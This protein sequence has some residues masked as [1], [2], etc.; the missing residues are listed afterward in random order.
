MTTN[1]HN[2]HLPATPI[3]VEPT[4]RQMAA[5]ELLTAFNDVAKIDWDIIET[6]YRTLVEASGYDS[7]VT[8]V[9]RAAA[10]RINEALLTGRESA[11]GRPR[12]RAL[13]HR[14]GPQRQAA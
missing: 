1:D 12:C 10:A 6:N 4:V 9:G 11:S 7:A 5:H 2:G 14:A 13:R 8:E 3:D